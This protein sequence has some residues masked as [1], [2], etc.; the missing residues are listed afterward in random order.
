MF[1]IGDKV[2]FIGN[3]RRGWRQS[4]IMYYGTIVGFEKRYILVK[5]GNE[6]RRKMEDSL[7]KVAI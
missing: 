6:I 7:T 1:K 3:E 2:C 5:V 4:A